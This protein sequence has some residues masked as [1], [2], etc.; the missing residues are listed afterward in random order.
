[1]ITKLKPWWFCCG[2]E[3]YWCVLDRINHCRFTWVCDRHD[4]ALTR[5]Y[6]RNHPD[7]DQ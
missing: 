1:M 6:G 4:A 7:D 2:R 5:W 3:S